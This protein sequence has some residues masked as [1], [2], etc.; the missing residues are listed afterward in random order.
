MKK[1][2][3]P[4]IPPNVG[5]FMSGAAEPGASLWINADCVLCEQMT[6]HHQLLLQWA[7]LIPLEGQA[8]KA[9]WAATCLMGH[10]SAARLRVCIWWATTASR[11]VKDL[12]VG[13]F[14][15]WLSPLYKLLYPQKRH[16]HAGLLPVYLISMSSMLHIQK[17]KFVIMSQQ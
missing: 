15:A 11:S 6:P 14:R 1:R 8:K 10:L 16:P 7:V 3:L 9:P 13:T 12:V 17:W 4:H 2:D 5:T